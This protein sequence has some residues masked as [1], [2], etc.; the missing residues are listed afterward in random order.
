ML[1]G[2][3]GVSRSEGK[4][5]GQTILDNRRSRVA[6]AP[7]PINSTPVRIGH[8][9]ASTDVID[10]SFGDE[11][12]GQQPAQTRPAAMSEPQTEGE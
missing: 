3:F 11:Q 9:A 2:L 5:S 1:P 4:Q 8:A 12:L 6:I 7:T 10:G